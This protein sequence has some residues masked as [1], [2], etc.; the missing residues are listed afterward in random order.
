MK[1]IKKLKLALVGTDSMRGKEIKDLL[2]SKKFPVDDM[3]FFDPH[4]EEAYSKLTEFQGEPRVI[5]P[6]D[7]SGP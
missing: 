3:E 6:L 7:P 1:H 4:V 2:N 5:Q